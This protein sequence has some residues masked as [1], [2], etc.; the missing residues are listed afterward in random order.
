M[1]GILSGG[2]G[3][4][5][6]ELGTG[7][8]PALGKSILG[9]GGSAPSQVASNEFAAVTQQQ[10]SD[11]VNTFMPIENQLIQYATSPTTVSDAMSTASTGVQ[12]AYAAQQGTQQ[13]QNQELGV[14]LTPQQ[15]AAQKRDS[16]ISQSLA[17][18]SAQNNARDLA[19]QNQQSILGNPVPSTGLGGALA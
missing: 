13:R 10:W 9:G 11:Y 16:A 15:Q 18:V 12:N 1:S 4:Q 5:A 14:T 7:F 2:A 3:Q 6:A 8:F 17:D 19:T